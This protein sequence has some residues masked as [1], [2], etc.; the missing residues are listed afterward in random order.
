MSSNSRFTTGTA[1][2]LDSDS[3]GSSSQERSPNSTDS[4][5]RT[6]TL[7]KKNGRRGRAEYRFLNRKR[8]G[9]KPASKL[10]QKRTS[11]EGVC[12]KIT[13]TEVTTGSLAVRP[14]CSNQCIAR[15][16]GSDPELF[17]ACPTEEESR[18]RQSFVDAVIATR[19]AVHSEGQISSANYLM[20]RLRFGMS[21]GTEPLG[22]AETY[23]YP[24]QRETSCQEYWWRTEEGACVQVRP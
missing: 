9:P 24:L 19:K 18:Q 16:V 12:R 2:V 5:A 1:S 10:L 22:F 21:A 6:A 13:V 4:T 8:A 3:N 17:T 14:C 20:N 11:Q 15:L 7:I 23:S